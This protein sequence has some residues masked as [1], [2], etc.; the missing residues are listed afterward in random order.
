VASSILQL[1]ELHEVPRNELFRPKLKAP[2]KHP[3]QQQQMKVKVAVIL[4]IYITLSQEGKALYLK[5]LWSLPPSK[6]AAMV[7]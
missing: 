6:F 7:Q 3:L 4:G 1:Y 5:S 2:R